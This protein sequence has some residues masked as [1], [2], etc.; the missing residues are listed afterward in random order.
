MPRGPRLD[1]PGVVHHVMVRGIEQSA[2]FQN[3]D[4]RADFIRRLARLLPDTQTTCLAWCVLPNH[5][6]LALRSGPR[7]LPQLMRRLLTGYAVAFNRRHGRVG[8]LFQNRYQSIVCEEEPYLPALVRYVHLNPVRAGIV[9]GLRALVDH[10]WCGHGALMG[11]VEHPWQET[12]EVLARFGDTLEHARREYAAFLAAEPDVDDESRP[13]SETA[14]RLAAG[15]IAAEL[16]ARPVGADPKGAWGSP[17]FVA[18]LRA[19]TAHAQPVA[20]CRSVVEAVC[21][22]LGLS[23][24][25]LASGRRTRPLSNGRAVVAYVART[26]YRIAG[27]ELAQALG[28]SAPA[29]TLAERRGAQLIKRRVDL[30]TGLQEFLN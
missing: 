21:R 2:I 22:A 13:R 3:D 8:H 12:A 25:A 14:E 5:V 20:D 4:D 30:R 17:E 18:G 1:A 29:V 6:H 7:G 16:P 27:A 23:P 15:A 9:N 11:R 10:P 19:Q 26:R 28:M 24:Q